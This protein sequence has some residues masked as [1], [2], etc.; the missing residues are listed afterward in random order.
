MSTKLLEALIKLFAIIAKEDGVTREERENV[1]LVLSYELNERITESYLELFDRE[2]EKLLQVRE[3]TDEPLIQELC[4]SLNKELTRHQKISVLLQLIAITIADGIVT[5]R[6][7]ELIAHIR[8]GLHIEEQEGK[9]IRQYVIGRSP[10]QL[11][12]PNILIIDA[13]KY[14]DRAKFQHIY[15]APIDGYLAVLH[16]PESSSYFLKNMGQN[17]VTLNGIILPVNHIR[18]M[19][20]GSSLKGKFETLYY[21][22]IV[23]TFKVAEAAP[24]LCME[25]DQVSYTFKNGNIGLHEIS[26]SENSGRLLGIMGASGAGKSTLLNILNGSEKPTTGN[27]I[28]NGIDLYKRATSLEGIIGFVPQDDLLFDQLTVYQNLYYAA[29]LCFASYEENKLIQLVEKILTNL[30][31][32]E[33]KNLQ[34]GSPLDK[35]ISG[36]QRKR[37]NIALE[38]L[39]EPSI[40]FV[41]EPTSGLSSRDSENIMDLLKEL[42]L[43]GKIVFVVIHQPSSAIFKMF[44]R[45]LILDT[46]GYQIFYGNPIEAIHYFKKSSDH[47]DSETGE[48]PVCGNVNPEQIFDII[49][50]KV[51]DEYGQLTKDRRTTPEEWRELFEKTSTS[52]SSIAKVESKPV[53][54]LELPG[55]FSQMKIFITRDILAKI[56]NLQ[57]VL[58]NLLEAPLLALILAFIVRYSPGG[59]YIFEKNQNIPSY[60][61]MGIIVAMF[62]GLTVSAEEIIKDKKILRR[63]K[64]LN[65]SRSSYLTSKIAIQFGISALQTLIFVLIAN[66]ILEIKGMYLVFWAILFSVAAFSNV[67]GLMISSAMNSVV[68]VYILIPFLLIPQILL[69]GVVVKFDQLQN[70]LR[71]DENVP[72]IGDLMVSRWALEASMVAQFCQNEFEKVYYPLDK[73]LS[74]MRYT[75]VY[76]LPKLETIFKEGYKMTSSD[77]QNDQ[78]AANRKLTLVRHELHKMLDLVGQDKLVEVDKVTPDKIDQDVY[79]AVLEFLKAYKAY[80]HGKQSRAMDAKDKLNYHLNGLGQYESL[81]ARYNNE[82]IRKT[83]TNNLSLVRI[84]EKKDRLVRLVDPIFITDLSPTNPFDYRTPLYVPG[85]YF[86][87]FILPT[88]LFN[89][90]VIWIFTSL[91]TLALY[92]NWLKKLMRLSIRSPF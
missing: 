86:L 61:F 7:D 1:R 41:D 68:T 48:C 38:L 91:L 24:L 50:T 14:V 11:N 51:I 63:E 85:K 37:V 16:I 59:S 65:L 81:K 57:Y 18:P 62:L 34:V 52:S 83:V 45:L 32:L 9:A 90:L 27:V 43:N 4:F 60:L 30:G 73:V 80:A 46:G 76:Y 72:V 19:S 82:L 89:I 58:I 75:T 70:W 44:D 88:P 49:E 55:W 74:D 21:S 17:E 71:N 25:V 15:R 36:G 23:A 2:A 79:H 77:D 87:G 5:E 31:L 22:D 10:G 69:S 84:I 92:R 12:N 67:L 6:E 64:F 40:L 8:E 66:S 54:S 3:T 56:T 35:V 29:K 53:S 28:I 20:P 78:S 42:A 39:R 47:V 26:F 13:N 33:I